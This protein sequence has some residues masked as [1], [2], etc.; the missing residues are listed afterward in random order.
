MPPDLFDAILMAGLPVAAIT[1]ALFAWAYRTGKVIPRDEW[2]D[3]TDQDLDNMGEELSDEIFGS[4]GS[5]SAPGASDLTGTKSSNGYIM[6]KWVE[7]GGGYYGLMTTL[8]FFHLELQELLGLGEIFEKL[9]D[10]E[11]FIHALLQFGLQLF[12]DAIMN[13]VNAFMWWNHWATELPIPDGSG[14]LW[15]GVS[16]GGYLAGEWLAGFFRREPPTAL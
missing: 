1:F 8:T 11:A 9:G 15:L 3:S 10:V 13:M 7:F 2:L 4:L 6:D 5:S 16:Y 12:L 14:F